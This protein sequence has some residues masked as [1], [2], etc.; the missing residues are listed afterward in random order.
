[1]LLLD[2][3]TASRS[4]LPYALE[5]KPEAMGLDLW[6]RPA[7]DKLYRE[8]G[9]K[10]FFM[11]IEGASIDHAS[12]PDDLATAIFETPSLTAVCE[13]PTNFTRSTPT[14]PSSSSLPTTKPEPDDG[15]NQYATLPTGNM[16]TT[17]LSP[18]SRSPTCSVVEKERP[19]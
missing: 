16:S 14:R 15:R 2:T 3:D 6:Y 9:K 7:S 17:R 8:K 1:M 19:G 11:M 12:H 10:G 5:R 13:S 4:W 18:K